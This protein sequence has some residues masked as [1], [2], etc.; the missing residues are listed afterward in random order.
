[1]K[2]LSLW[3]LLLFVSVSHAIEFFPRTDSGARCTHDSLTIGCGML[4]VN[5]LALLVEEVTDEYPT[6]DNGFDG[7]MCAYAPEINQIWC[8]NP[9]E[10]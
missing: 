10:Q 4:W 9:G 2:T 7:G 8:C 6:G 3:Q 1:M 5:V